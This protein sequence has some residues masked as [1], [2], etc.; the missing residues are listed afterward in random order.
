MLTEKIIIGI[1]FIGLGLLFFF[2][3]INIA[4]GAFKFYKKLYTEKNLKIM[5]NALGIIL[6]IG[7][8]ILILLK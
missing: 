5:F 1:I 8:L 7:G 6:V 2:N 3:N 4:K